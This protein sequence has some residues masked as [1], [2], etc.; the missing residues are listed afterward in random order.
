[1]TFLSDTTRSPRQRWSP[2][3]RWWIGITAAVVVIV[4]VSIFTGGRVTTNNGEPTSNLVGKSVT[5]FSLGGLKSGTVVAPWKR[6]HA[7]VLI[8]FASY[9]GPCHSEMPK[10][11]AYLRHHN[12]GSIRVIGVD[13]GYDKRSAAQTFVKKSGVTFPV[14]YDPT[15]TVTTGIFQFATVPETAFVTAKGVVNQVY[16]GAIPKSVL[17]QGIAALRKA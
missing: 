13:A 4:V 2:K 1:L 9:C 12:E 6:D 15:D 7:A 14:A 3:K 10:V 5:A 8:F 17:V 11:A 16:F